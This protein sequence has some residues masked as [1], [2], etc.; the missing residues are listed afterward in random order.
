MG[1]WRRFVGTFSHHCA[2]DQIKSKKWQHNCVLVK[3]IG[4]TQLPQPPQPAGAL[5]NTGW[6]FHKIS[7][8]YPD[9]C[10]NHPFWLLWYFSIG[11]TPPPRIDGLLFSFGGSFSISTSENSQRF[12]NFDLF[13]LGAS[14]QTKDNMILHR[15]E[16]KPLLQFNHVRWY[17]FNII[18]LASWGSAPKK[19]LFSGLRDET[20]KD[21]NPYWTGKISRWHK[22]YLTVL[23]GG[24]VISKRS[25]PKL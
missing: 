6:W 4:Q 8:F 16:R 23:N 24:C 5:M 18:Y 21:E 1:R 7:P 22:E 3:D 25:I 15:S 20:Q 9:P 11:L 19:G 10:G 14:L 2:H 13:L 12:I 17:H